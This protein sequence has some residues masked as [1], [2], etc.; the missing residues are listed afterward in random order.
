M[1]RGYQKKFLDFVHLNEA[2]VPGLRNILESVAGRLGELKVSSQRQKRIVE[3]AVYE[4]K[5]ARLAE[6]RLSEKLNL[7]EEQVKLLEEGRD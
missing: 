6:R 2:N 4:L 1:F 7:L 3:M 5:Q